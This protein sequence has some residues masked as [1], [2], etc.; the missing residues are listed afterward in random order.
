M[1]LAAVFRASVGAHQFGK[2]A[3]ESGRLWTKQVPD[4]G[5]GEG[6]KKDRK[7]LWPTSHRIKLL[8]KPKW[9]GG[10]T[11]TAGGG[12]TAVEVQQPAVSSHPAQCR[13]TGVDISLGCP[14]PL[15]TPSPPA[16]LSHH[17]HSSW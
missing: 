2:A 10:Q 17:W 9:A 15:G 3:L 8:G 13:D 7:S 1:L 16:H 5:T 11:R 12:I 4:A 14:G 6:G